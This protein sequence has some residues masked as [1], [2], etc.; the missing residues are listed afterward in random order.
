MLI[1]LKPIRR[2]WVPK[3]L[4]SLGEGKGEKKKMIAVCETRYRLGKD[5]QRRWRWSDSGEEAGAEGKGVL[6]S[7]KEKCDE[8]VNENEGKKR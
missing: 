7:R 4:S 8:N 1:V 6:R 3:Q 5:F 2:P